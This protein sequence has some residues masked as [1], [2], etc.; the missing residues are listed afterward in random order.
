M[1]V[2]LLPWFAG[3]AGAQVQP[4]RNIE[5]YEQ[6]TPTE[7]MGAFQPKL[8]K[9]NELIGAKV[10]NDRNERLGTI[11]EVVLTPDRTSVNYVVLSYGGFWGFSSKLFAVPLSQFEIRADENVLVLSNVSKADLDKAKGF[12]RKSW[13]TTAHENWLGFV[14]GTAG[15][16]SGLTTAEPRDEAARRGMG[17]SAEHPE[18]GMTAESRMDRYGTPEAATPRTGTMADARY[19]DIKYHKLSE[20]TGMTIRNLEG[21]DL[22][23]LEDIV[24]DV[25]EGKVAYAVVSMRS[26]FLGLDKDLA[27]VPWS[28]FEILPRLEAARLNADKATLEAIAFDEDEFPN[29]EDMQYSR[30]IHQ[31]FNAT[32]Y[33][34]ALGFIPGEGR[35]RHEAVPGEA[36]ERRGVAPGVSPWQE[37]S[38]YNSL[39]NPNALK[40]LHGT[41]ES[42]GTFRLEG[43]DIEG[44]RLRIR[45]DDD[46][47]VTVHAGPRLYL[48]RQNIGFHY[49]DEVTVI[50]SEAKWGWRDVF[51]ASQ[52]KV[53][54]KTIDLRTREGTPRWN[55]DELKSPGAIG[56]SPEYKS[57]R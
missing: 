48:E 46:K 53:G 15:A 23:E 45:T 24:I 51:L 2:A 36:R 40:T 5:E 44:L 18:H 4:D 42:V 49:G 16:P 11:E 22:G 9:A 12:D 27:V 1:A 3:P 6:V 20:L 50:G 32:P 31:R 28:A 52:I 30:D 29:L 35:E 41:I 37:G 57:S 19:G 14:P 25:H 26:G 47:T 8:E 21:E 7:H 17:P 34:E 55:I 39:Y 43:T 56:S 13:P 54:D 33:W 10:I 38:E